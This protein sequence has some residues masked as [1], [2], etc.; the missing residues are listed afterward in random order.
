MTRAFYTGWFVGPVSVITHLQS[1]WFI[2][3]EDSNILL[4]LSNLSNIFLWEKAIENMLYWFKKSTPEKSL[5]CEFLLRIGQYVADCNLMQMAIY[6]TQ[7]PVRET[8]NLHS[9]LLNCMHEAI[10]N[11]ARWV[12]SIFNLSVCPPTSLSIP[13]RSS[14]MWVNYKL[15]WK[16][17]YSILRDKETQNSYLGNKE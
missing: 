17:C 3:L 4:H 2:C 15:F 14:P 11:T 7:K 6:R 5:C 1:Y 12:S 8:V 16:T 10:R 9:Y 13:Q